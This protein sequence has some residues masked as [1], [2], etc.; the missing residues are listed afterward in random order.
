MSVDFLY[1][2]PEWII[3]SLFFALVLAAG[4]AGFRFGRSAQA[5][6]TEK[7]AAQISVVAGSVLGTLALLL[8]FTMSMAVSRFEVRKQL[9]LEEANAIGTSYLRTQ[10]LPRPESTEIG[11]RLREYVDLRVHFVDVGSDPERI[12]DAREKALRLQ[13]QF[14]PQAVAYARKYPS[15]VTTGLLLQS[16]NQAIDMEAAQWMAL[17]NHVP[18]TV[19]YAN[20]MVAFLAANIVGYTFGLQGRRQVFSTCLLALAITLVLAVILDLDRPR[21]GFIHVGQQPMVDLQSQLRAPG[22]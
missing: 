15:P 5:R 18:V 22:N 20:A 8:G 11:N 2:T 9:V 6:T 12:K 7:T 4:E 14:W 19:I 21:Q 3:D 13:D 17:Q 1:A 16:L 10:L